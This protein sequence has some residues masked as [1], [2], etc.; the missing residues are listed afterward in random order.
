M[1]VLRKNIHRRKIVTRAGGM[2]RSLQTYVLIV[3]QH[4][5][6]LFHLVG[7]PATT[8]SI[9]CAEYQQVLRVFGC[10]AMQWPGMCNLFAAG[11][12][13]TTQGPNMSSL[14]AAADS[15]ALDRCGTVCRMRSVD[16]EQLLRQLLPALLTRQPSCHVCR[17]VTASS[18]TIA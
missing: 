16:R 2:S 4:T 11:V 10:F 9:T 5:R 6:R 7:R 1:D 13:G 12:W 18:L 8:S 3:Q 17:R 14:M 15:I